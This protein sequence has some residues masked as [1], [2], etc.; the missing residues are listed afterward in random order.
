[1]TPE[2][3][4]KISG[5]NVIKAFETN[6]VKQ[7]CNLLRQTYRKVTLSCFHALGFFSIL[8][9]RFWV[10]MGFFYFLFLAPLRPEETLLMITEV[11]LQYEACLPALP[12]ITTKIST[13]F[14]SHSHLQLLW[15]AT[16][17]TSASTLLWSDYFFCFHQKNVALEL[18]VEVRNLN[19]PQCSSESISVVPYVVLYR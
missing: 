16:A 4:F 6:H 19:S 9:T 15:N 5:K 3:V 11:S 17:I 18:P 14:K 10:F 12:I 7:C 8:Q 13:Q 1:M 2:S